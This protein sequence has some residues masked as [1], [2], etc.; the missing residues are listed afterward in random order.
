MKA[1]NVKNPIPA[2]P[3]EWLREIA[4]AYCDARDAIPFAELID[5]KEE[6]DE[7][8][9]FHFAPGVCLKFRGIRRTK[10]I[11][12]QTTEAALSSYVATQDKAAVEFESP[13]MAFAF[14]YVASHF[15]LGLIT[16]EHGYSIIEFV[17]V[18]RA[19]LIHLIDDEKN[20]YDTTWNNP[21]NRKAFH[22]KYCQWEK[23]QWLA[24]LKENLSFPFDVKRM[25]DEDD[26][27]FT[28]IARHEPFRLGRTFSVL[29]MSSEDDLRGIFVK[30]KEGR[31]TGH[32]PLCDVEVTSRYNP[33]YW[34]V[35]EYV[36][37]F[38]NR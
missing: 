16:E 11:I 9:I 38:A 37:W 25:E 13:V 29:G 15:G 24:W 33:N 7:K 34:P 20:K 1:I 8:N 5:D 32:V 3:E 22:D 2:K 14:C 27:Y 18:R 31:K 19:E 35:K 26:A 12:E 4:E 17:E 36:V 30:V 6:F 23:R 28:D 21:G 10:N